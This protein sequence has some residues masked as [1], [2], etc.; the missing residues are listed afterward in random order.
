[1]LLALLFF[2]YG[3]AVFGS[4]VYAYAQAPQGSDPRTA[5]IVTGGMAAVAFVIAFAAMAWRLKSGLFSLVRSVATIIPLAFGALAIYQGIVAHGAVRKYADAVAGF[6][7]AQ[8][9]AMSE[10]GVPPPPQDLRSYIDT[11]NAPIIQRAIAEGRLSADAPD[12]ERRRLIRAEGT[13]EH[14]RTFLRNTL[15]VIGGTSLLVFGAVF[16]TR[17]RP[18]KPAP[19]PTPAPATAAK[20]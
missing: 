9:R 6:S 1:M 18:P 19:A 11:L 2:L 17:P 13:P 8:S 14:D 7:Q 3:L 5:L 16:L 12:S 15:F 10:P 4:G 20:K